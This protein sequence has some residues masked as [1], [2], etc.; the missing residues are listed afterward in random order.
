MKRV[1][2][3]LGR[4]LLG[5]LAISIVL[6][7]VIAMTNATLPDASPVLDRLSAE[8]K[9]QVAEAMHVR[10][11]LGDQVWPGWGDSSFPLILFNESGDQRF[12]MLG[13]LFFAEIFQQ[14]QKGLLSW[15][16]ER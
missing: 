15:A 16:A 13:E 10:G 11:A 5:V 4:L 1:L 9:A 3:W 2:R 14:F 7:L 6:I 12:L 8:S